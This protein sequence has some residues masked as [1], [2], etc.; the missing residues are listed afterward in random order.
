MDPCYVE[1]PRD[2]LPAPTGRVMAM[3]EESADSAGSLGVTIEAQFTVGEYGQRRI[4]LLR[5]GT[6]ALCGE[7]HLHLFAEI[8]LA[9]EHAA[10]RDQ[11]RVCH[12]LLVDIAANAGAHGA[13]G[14]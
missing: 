9:V 13:L 4:V 2:Y 3:A 5:S 1:P 10:D 12:L 14:I 11:H 8:D 7:V 6:K